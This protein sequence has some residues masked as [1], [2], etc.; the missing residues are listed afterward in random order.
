MTVQEG[1][2]TQFDWSL[3]EY[4]WTAADLLPSARALVAAA[5][6]QPGERV[7]DIGCGTGSAALLAAEQGGLVTGIEPAVRLREVAQR[8]AG[9]R[10]LPVSV[11]D[12]TAA[13]I[14]LADGVADVLLSNFG[15]IFA[16]DPQAAVAELAR[17]T[18]LAGRILF[19]VW[20]PGGVLNQLNAITI[21]AMSRLTGRG[22]LDGMFNWHDPN[23]LSGLFR[24][25]GLAISVSERELEIAVPSA[26]AYWRN[27]LVKHPIGS[28]VF[29]VLEKAGVLGQVRADTLA[30]L[31]E[32]GPSI[33]AHYLLVEARR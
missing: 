5:E 21:A 8:T 16:P 3:G 4:E 30:L 12:G 14:P 17:V 9:Q 11:L 20:L 33:S 28:T 7:L 2:M 27:R 18:A 24:P 32:A 29:P 15:L 25:H 22:Q 13:A 19:T 10:G 31:A 1:Q 6:I 23:A 26:E